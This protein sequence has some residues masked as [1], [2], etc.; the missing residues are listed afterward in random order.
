MKVFL[1]IGDCGSGKTWVM[2]QV[3]KQYKLNTLGKI[4]MF[5]FHRNDMLMCLGKYDGSKFQGSDKLSMAIMRDVQMFKKHVVKED[6]VVVCEGDRFM[7]DTFIKAMSPNLTII[8]IT[9]DGS[10]GRKKRKSTQTERQ[11]KSIH[12]RVSKIAAGAKYQ[13]LN[14]DVALKVLRDELKAAVL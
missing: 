8:H 11:I 12:T 5:Y 6:F 1:L 2:E 7:N 14:S 9:D 10:K 13:C 4:G 3:I